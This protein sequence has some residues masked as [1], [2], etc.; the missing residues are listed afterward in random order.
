M[1]LCY[2]KCIVHFSAIYYL[3][4]FLYCTFFNSLFWWKC[5]FELWASS[6][7]PQQKSNHLLWSV[8]ITTTEVALPKFLAHG[9]QGLDYISSHLLCCAF[10]W[11]HAMRSNLFCSTFLWDNTFCNYLLSSSK[12]LRSS[13]L[14]LYVVDVVQTLRMF[15]SMATPNS[16]CRYASLLKWFKHVYYTC[17]LIFIHWEVQLPL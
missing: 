17:F 1:N 5:A 10:L 16:S 15:K 13:V 14:N 9:N 3:H 7:T 6:H 8:Q 12:I 4:L 11:N 2:E